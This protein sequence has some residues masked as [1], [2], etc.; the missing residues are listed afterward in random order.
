MTGDSEQ[1]QLGVLKKSAEWKFC[2]N[3]FELRQIQKT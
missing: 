3:D 1:T 2:Q